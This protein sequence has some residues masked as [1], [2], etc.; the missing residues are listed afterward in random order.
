MLHATLCSLLLAGTSAQEPELV[1]QF[2]PAGEPTGHEKQ[3]VEERD[4]ARRA[5]RARLPLGRDGIDRIAPLAP[6]VEGRTRTVAPA[7]LEPAQSASAS[8]RILTNIDLSIDRDRVHMARG[9][10]GTWLRG[11]T[12]KAHVSDDGFTYIPFLGSDV[13]TTYPL[14]FRLNRATLAGTDVE[15]GAGCVRG[16]QAET[17]RFT[18]ERGSLDV[19]YDLIG[20]DTIE[21]TVA[22]DAAGADGTLV[23]DFDVA[24]DMRAV[25]QPS[26]AIR[27][28]ARDDAGE[29][30]GGVRYGEATVLDGAGRQAAMTTEWQDGRL[31]LTVPADFLRSAQGQIVVDPLVT[32]FTVDSVSGFQHDVDVTYK[33]QY[34]TPNEYLIYVYEDQFAGNDVDIYTTILSDD[35]TFVA[36]DYIEIGTENWIDPAVASDLSHAL[37]VAERTS[38]V[39]GTREI[40][41]RRMELTPGFPLNAV[42]LHGN[43]TGNYDDIAPDVASAGSL[44]PGDAAF[45]VAWI[46]DFAT[47]G[48]V[49]YQTVD[50]TG[51]LGI[52]R[53]LETDVNIDTTLFAIARRPSSAGAPPTAIPVAWGQRNVATNL[54]TIEAAQIDTTGALRLWPTTVQTFGP[55]ARPGEI[56]VAAPSF[57]SDDEQ[58]WGI[59]YDPYDSTDEDVNL[60][61]LNGT[62]V[63]A[64][65]DLC[66]AQH[67]DVERDQ[68]EARIESV[69]ER[70]LVTYL[71]SDPVAGGWRGYVQ[72]VTTVTGIAA[73]ARSRVE[74]GVVT[75]GP[76]YHIGGGI[77]V[78]RYNAFGAPGRLGALAWERNVG[79]EIDVKGGVVD[80]A[81]RPYGVGVQYCFGAPNST[82]ERGLITAA[83]ATVSTSNMRLFADRLPPGSLGFFVVGDTMTSVSMPGGSAGVLCIGGS[84]GRYSGTILSSGSNGSVNMVVEFDAIPQPGGPVATVPGTTWNFSYWHRDSVSGTATSNFTNAMSVFVGS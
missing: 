3:L 48:D 82:G 35:G 42:Q 70:F 18:I 29:L 2:H 16:T 58:P 22:I 75:D 79:G 78:T 81:L 12:Y 52:V 11:A 10:D 28:E 36:G 50:G 67:A 63:F 6:V 69:N 25:P 14:E 21:Q 5:A 68:A 43:S 76:V 84:V 51:A 19:R 41:S 66:V 60:L 30:I 33:T 9:E 47:D 13:P 57:V 20:A 17:E 24:T 54:W 65:L 39:L 8:D 4:A 83:G 15:L 40:V 74:L 37:F 72:D 32:T 61:L 55:G 59:V 27:F 77:P 38:P 31:R 1:R 44:F 53:A 26:G 45:V 80:F 62:S 46:R 49:R 71:E 73:I 64:E 23:L 34:F 56:D 7:P